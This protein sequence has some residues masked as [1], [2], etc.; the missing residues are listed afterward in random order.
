M[1]TTPGAAGVQLADGGTAL[2]HGGCGGYGLKNGTFRTHSSHG[3]DRLIPFLQIVCA[4]AWS[5]YKEKA[6]PALIKTPGHLLAPIPEGPR[7][8]RSL[9]RRRE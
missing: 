8:S 3:A 7:R 9:G 1:R 4:E 6:E 2:A 5:S